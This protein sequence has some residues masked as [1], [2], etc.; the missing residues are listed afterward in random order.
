MLQS[1]FDVTPVELDQLGSEPAVAVLREMLWAEANTLGVPISQVDVPFAVTTSDGGIDAIVNGTPQ[2]PGNGLIFAPRTTY[3]VKAG[4]FSLNATSLGTIEELLISPSAITA[5]K[6]NGRKPGDTFHTADHISPRVRACLDAGGTFVVMLF[7]NDSID[8]EEDATEGAIRDFL[9]KVDGK[10][11]AEQIKVWRQ[12]RICGLLRAFPAV[13]L[14]IKNLPGFQL[15]THS[16]WAE[17]YDLKQ[18]F[19][20]APDQQTVIDNLRTALRDDSGGPLHVR[21]IGEPGIGKTRLVLE[22]LRAD[23]LK[24][25]VLYADRGTK[26]DGSVISAIYNAKSARII[27][28]VDECNPDIRSDLV[29][30]FASLGARVKIISIYQDRDQTDDASEYRLSVMPPLPTAE[31]ET[32]LRATY[33]VDPAHVSG[34]A[35][36][37]EGSPGLLT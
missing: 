2:G 25:L 9:A 10:Y 16:Q 7:G 35:T 17:R 22:T 23:D 4:A 8:T 27:L 37:C 1:F 31:I 13:S 14:Q 29:R 36:L 18:E 26:V 21:V 28:V 20:A 5:R 3:Q 15:L 6:A 11:A 34:W 19:V 12:S 30:N 32:I 24:P 33:D